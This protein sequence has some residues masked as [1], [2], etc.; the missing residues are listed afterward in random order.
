MKFLASIVGGVQNAAS[1]AAGAAGGFV[2]QNV[3]GANAVLNTVESPI[4]TFDLPHD[5][6]NIKIWIAIYEVHLTKESVD[7]IS[8][9]KEF[10]NAV[11]G[12]VG[13]LVGS[14]GGTLTPAAP[15]LVA[16]LTAE[17]AAVQQLCNDN[18]VRLRG[19]YA[20]PMGLVVPLPG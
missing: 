5:S 3:P 4:K 9:I 20:P 1:A 2:R 11:V 18:G 17:W 12:L 8:D 16:Y 15:F 13:T 10:G 14:S 19:Q 6:G 7:A